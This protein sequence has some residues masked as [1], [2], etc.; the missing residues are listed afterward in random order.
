[1][2]VAAAIPAEE[3]AAAVLPK[4]KGELFY[5]AHLFYVHF[6]RFTASPHFSTTRLAISM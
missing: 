6:Y 2:V 4:R 5:R 3:A 1:M